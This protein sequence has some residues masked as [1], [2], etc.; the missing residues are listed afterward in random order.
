MAYVKIAASLV[1]REMLLQISRPMAEMTDEQ[2]Q[3]A[4]I[5]E[6]EASQKVIEHRSRSVSVLVLIVFAQHLALGLQ[7]YRRRGSDR[8]ASA[9]LARRRGVRGSMIA[10]ART[11]GFEPKLHHRLLCAKLEGVA[12]GEIRK[13][14]FPAPRQREIDLLQPVC[15]LVPGTCAGQ[16]GARRFAHHRNG[17][18]LLAPHPRV[19]ARARHHSRDHTQRRQPGR[20]PLGTHERWRVH[21]GGCGLSHT[22]VSRGRRA[23]R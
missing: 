9:E 13:L 15:S 20:K 6:Q 14:M 21:G 23:D 16:R 8:G 19:G 5:E 12:R 1:P 22:R 3:A 2:L 18:A 10:W 7:A 17:R 11:C 4:A